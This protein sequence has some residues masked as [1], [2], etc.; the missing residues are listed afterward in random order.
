MAR[1]FTFAEQWT[2]DYLDLLNYAISIGD[3]QWQ[4]EIIAKLSH[5]QYYI[6]QDTRKAIRF[7]L[8][9]R[10]DYI[11]TTL[12][13]LFQQIRASVNDSERK[14]LEEKVWALK[15]QRVKIGRALRAV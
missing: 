10:F 4:D 11:N 9:Q 3:V 13:E 1:N 14:K 15:W 12:L 8:W 2:N 7:T 5:R 6:E